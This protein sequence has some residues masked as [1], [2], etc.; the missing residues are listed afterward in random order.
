MRI[1]D[2]SVPL[3]GQTPTYLG[4]AKPQVTETHS[5]A[6]N[7]FLGHSLC[8][9]THVGTHL[10]APIHMIA[11]GLAVNA[12]AL[13]RTTGRLVYVAAHNGYQLAALEALD[14]QQGDAVIFHTGFSDKYH[15]PSYFT[16]YPE[17]PDAVAA[18]LA[19]RQVYLVGSDTYSIDKTPY[20]QHH[21]LLSRNILLLE[22]LTNLQAVRA[23]NYMLCAFPLNVALDGSPVRAVAIEQ[24]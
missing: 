14:I 16:D 21:Y 3:N 1:I 19:D 17:M 11:D 12:V 23:G 18:Y 24:L 5:L 20:P 7:G 10:D 22:N 2:L 4:E 13:E 15:E 9:A 8:V 6:R